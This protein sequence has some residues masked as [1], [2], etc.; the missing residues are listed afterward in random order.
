MFQ[1]GYHLS[2]NPRGELGQLS[3]LIEEA[4]EAADAQEQ[5]ARLMVLVELSDLVGAMTALCHHHGIFLPPLSASPAPRELF[6]VRPVLAAL[7]ALSV[8]R[9]PVS[10]PSSIQGLCEVRQ[11]VCD[12]LKTTHPSLTWNDLDIM[13]GVTAWAFRS[14]RRS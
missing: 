11:L 7:E 13:A 4:R 9:E 1:P 14:G 2:P 5:G 6:C 12:Y 8:S 3:K 10:S